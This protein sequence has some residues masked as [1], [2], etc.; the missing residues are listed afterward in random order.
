MR[1]RKCFR[2]RSRAQGG[3]PR[4]RSEQYTES[5]LPGLTID[6]RGALLY[7]ATPALSLSPCL[8][9]SPPRRLP[10]IIAAPARSFARSVLPYARVSTFSL[11]PRPGRPGARRFLRER[12]CRTTSRNDVL[13][14]RNKMPTVSAWYYSDRLS[15]SLLYMLSTRRA[16]SC[17]TRLV[18]VCD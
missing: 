4:A 18:P 13:S 11:L 12:T 1:H 17:Q 5:G 9:A 14:A 10:C 3:E 8:S 15:L 2:A 7:I 16:S 6:A